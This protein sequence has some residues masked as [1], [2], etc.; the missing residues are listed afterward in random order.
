MK[1]LWTESFLTGKIPQ[2]Y[3]TQIIIP[4]HK[5]GPKTSPENW[6]PISITPNPIKIFERILRR[7]INYLESNI[8]LSNNQ[9]GF[10]HSRSCS[11]QLMEQTHYIFENLTNGNEIDTIYLDYSKA[12]DKI[13]HTLLLKK[14]KL[15]G[16]SDPYIKWLECFIRGRTQMVLVDNNLSFPTTV[17]SGVPQGSVLAPILFII[18][19]NDLFTH[20][21]DCRILSFADD[22]KLIANISSVQDTRNLQNN[23]ENVFHWSR[24]NN[25]K[26]NDDKFELIRFKPNCNNKRLNLLNNLPFSDKYSHYLLPSNTVLEPSQIVKDLGIFIDNKLDWNTHIFKT[27]NKARRITGWILNT[28]VSRD[29]LTMTTLFNS[30]VRPILEY[31]CEIWSP[32]KLQDISQIEQIQRAFTNRITGMDDLDYWERLKSLNIMSLQRRR[33]KIIITAIWKIKNK[34]IPNSINIKFKDHL[35]SQACKAILPPLPRTGSNLLSKYEESFTIKGAKLWNT[36]PPPL[37]K[38][39]DISLFKTSLTKFLNKIPDRPP[40]PGYNR[41]NNNSLVEIKNLN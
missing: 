7:K 5:K 19:V 8:L 2:Q 37:T 34:L 13:D 30:L 31:N 35:R 22:T 3:K 33:E 41:A 39:T 21:K 15:I 6:R 14:L 17:E 23:L 9:H 40:L 38:I 11:T 10:R 1:K 27:C 20:V 18:Y 32:F 25:M 28:F 24:L 36:L 26:L 16:I 4:I 29:K 12:F